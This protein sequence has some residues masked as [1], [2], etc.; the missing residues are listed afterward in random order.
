MAAASGPRSARRLPSRI[1]CKT[2]AAAKDCDGH[3]FPKNFPEGVRR[4]RDRPGGGPCRH[5]ARCRHGADGRPRRGSRRSCRRQRRERGRLPLFQR[6][7]GGLHGGRRR[8]AD[9]A[10]RRRPERDWKPAS[11]ASST[12]SWRAPGA[13]ASGS[14]AA[15]PWQQGAPTQGYQLPFTPAELFRTALRG[16]K[17]DLAS[18]KRTDIRCARRRRAGR[19]PDDAADQL[20][21]DLAGVPGNVFFE[22]LLAMT[23]EG[24]FSDPV[25]GGNLG[26]AAWKMI[27]F[28]GAYGG[29]LRPGRPARHRLPGR[30]AQPGGKRPRRDSDRAVDSRAAGPTACGPARH[31]PP[32]LRR[33]N[34]MTTHRT[35][36]ARGRRRAHR[37]GPGGLHPRRA[38]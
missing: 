19:L 11:R 14:T 26:M 21:V 34:A 3:R 4:R 13:R 15:G 37:R 6:R 31:R 27:G 33:R 8:A 35:R 32:T 30:A 29:L 10:G 22:S 20:R 9:P 23:I 5:A 1:R 18:S 38:N 17:A 36:T 2:S 24:Y 7:R 28:P 12:S 25:Y 16:I